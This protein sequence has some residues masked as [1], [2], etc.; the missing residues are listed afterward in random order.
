MKIDFKLNGEHVEFD[1]HPGESLFELLRRNGHSEVK[2]N[3]CRTGECGACTI[4]LDGI[5]V[6]SCSI[7]AG[8]VKG[9]SII[10]IKGIGDVDNPHPLQEAFVEKAAVQCGYCIPGIILSMKSLLDKTP[11]PTREDIKKVLSGHLCRCTGYIQQIEAVEKVINLLKGKGMS[12]VIKKE[13]LI[14]DMDVVGKNVKKYDGIVLATGQPVYT[15]D[16][17]LPNMLH[18]KLLTSPY[19]HAEIIDID[20]S[21][22]EKLPGV[23]IILTY[24]NTPRVPHTT[25][26]QGYPEP[27]PYDAFMFDKKVRFVGD[28]VAAVGADS[29]EI[30]EEALKL[31]KVNYKKLPSV[32]DPEEAMRKGAPII[33]DEDESTGIFDKERNIVSHVEIDIGDVDKVIRESDFSFEGYYTT[34][35]YVQHVPMETHVTITYL[36]ENER[37]VIRSSTQVP[38]HVRRILSYIFNI[39]LNRIRVIK[40]RIGGGF[41]TKQEIVLEDIC[42]LMTLRTKRPVRMEFTRREEFISARTRHPSKIWIRL[43]AESSGILT[44]IDM[45]VM[46]N[47]GAYGT[48]APTVLFNVGS[49]T[50]PIYNKAKNVRF[51]GDTVYTNLPIAGAY[52]GYGAT[53]GY[54][55]LETAIDEL[56]N[57]MGIDPVEFRKR[58]HIREGETSP[59]FEKLGEGR[60]GIPQTIESC[61]LDKCIEIGKREIEWEKWKGKRFKKGPYVRGV[62]MAILMQGSGIPLVDMASAEIKMNDDGSFQLLV[63]ATD[64]GTGSDTILAQIAAE[65]METD[66]KS[67]FVYS[68]DTDFTPFDTGAYASSTT[69]VSGNAVLRAARDLKEKIIKFAAEILNEDPED[70]YVANSAVIST[71][72]G[73]S[74]TYK[75]IGIKSFYE[76]NQ[77]HL[78]GNGSFTPS[79]SP[80]P[81]AAHFVLVDIDTETG[82][83]IPVKYVAVVDAGIVIHPELARGQTIGALVNG[84]GYALTEELK[85]TK[86]GAPINPNFFDYKILTPLDLPEIVVK[87]VPTYEPTGPFGSKSVAEININGPAPAISN[88]VYDA[89]G[90]R[91]RKTPFTPERVFKLL[92]EMA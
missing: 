4:L 6:P 63:G 61:A 36:D 91:L 74:I 70:L 16:F 15:D 48:H 2:G 13:E 90:I 53:Q 80:P 24:K 22:A 92:K 65:E 46:L 27:S 29:P 72:T 66:Y 49:K 33:H 78:I 35:Q 30:A 59:V 68:S 28:R 3:N 57:K 54:F 69:Y 47:T 26:G 34:T 77:R 86:T 32:F 50:L 85:F 73:K 58:N 81:F 42:A 39:P 89:V 51:Y 62:G 11:N 1:A 17:N 82:K 43:G 67:V 7:L 20:T 8:R 60:E 52:R 21:E 76:T 45:R 40:P 31:I 5:P 79:K 75:E 83:I 64:I 41:G 19:A 37:L 38:F 25:A 87:F 44:A 55:A 88:A 10:T 12:K 71:K 14:K 9:R 23:R 84:L 56:A 18:A